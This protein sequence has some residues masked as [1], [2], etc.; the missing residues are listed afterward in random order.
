MPNDT[1]ITISIRD[2]QR[3]EFAGQRHTNGSIK[4]VDQAL[5]DWPKRLQIEGVAFRLEDTEQRDDIWP[6]AT[7]AWYVPVE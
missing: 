5:A 4:F 6:G 2:C 1:T 3:L 7:F